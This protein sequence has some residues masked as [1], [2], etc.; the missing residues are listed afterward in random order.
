MQSITSPKIVL[1]SAFVLL[2]FVCI[3]AR[4]TST[5]AD[6]KISVSDRLK[7]F[8]KTWNTI[9]KNVFDPGFNGVNWGQMREKY[10]PMA[11]AAGDKRQ[12]LGVLEKMLNELHSSHTEVEISGIVEYGSGISYVQIGDIWVVRAVAPNS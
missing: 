11:E 4:A 10:R 8:D 2:S 5:L 3:Q 1:L 7:V 9:N 6:L 12:L